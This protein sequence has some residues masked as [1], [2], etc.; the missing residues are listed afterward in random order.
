MVLIRRFACCV[1]PVVA[2]ARLRFTT[3]AEVPMLLSRQFL[4]QCVGYLVQI[5]PLAG[6]YFLVR[7]HLASASYDNDTVVLRFQW[8]AEQDRVRGT[9]W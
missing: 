9:V 7:G 1:L 2:A 4:D 6:E 5:E 8:L 3:T